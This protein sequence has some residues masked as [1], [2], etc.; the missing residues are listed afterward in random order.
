MS[1]KDDS[2]FLKEFVAEFKEDSEL[3][4]AT[5]AMGKLM[6]EIDALKAEN[7]NLK[8]ITE[9]IREQNQ[10]LNLTWICTANEVDRLKREVAVLSR[11]DMVLK[12][13]NEKFRK[14]LDSI[15]GGRCDA[16]YNPCEA[17]E[18]LEPRKEE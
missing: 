13:E 2:R 9:A 3:F 10:K 6:L 8:K 5:L 18:A 1:E 17:R 7:E 11:R 14:A 16:H 12:A 15:C 4:K